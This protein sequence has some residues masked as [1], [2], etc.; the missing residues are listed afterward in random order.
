MDKWVDGIYAAS[1]RMQ[2]RRFHPPSPPW[3][4]PTPGFRELFCQKQGLAVRIDPAIANYCGRNDS[5]T[6]SGPQCRTDG[7]HPG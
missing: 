1:R 2:E 7:A 4:P 6:N 5:T 3:I